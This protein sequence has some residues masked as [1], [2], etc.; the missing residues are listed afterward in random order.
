[1]IGLGF[2]G[3]KLCSILWFDE[4]RRRAGAGSAMLFAFDLLELAGGIRMMIVRPTI[5]RRTR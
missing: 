4:L 1:V 5:I 3:A 2:P